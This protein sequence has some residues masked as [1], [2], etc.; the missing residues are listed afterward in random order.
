[1]ILRIHRHT[2][3]GIRKDTAHPPISKKIGA[4]EINLDIVAE[5]TSLITTLNLGIFHYCWDPFMFENRVYLLNQRLSQ[6][7]N[8]MIVISDGDLIRNQWIKLATRRAGIRS[9]FKLI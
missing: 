5:E 8:K 9:T 6:E 1:L 4:V 3:N 2:E 7:K